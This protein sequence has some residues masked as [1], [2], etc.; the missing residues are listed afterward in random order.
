MWITEGKAWRK[1]ACLFAATALTLAG[2]AGNAQSPGPSLPR[3]GFE[4]TAQDPATYTPQ[5]AEAVALV[6]KWIATT[7]DHDTRKHMALVGDNVVFRADP[8][9]PLQHGARGYCAAFNFLTASWFGLNELYVVGTPSDTLV[10]MNRTDVNLPYNGSIY[11]GYPVPVAALL[12]VQNGRVV[13][14]FDMPT[15][16]VSIGALPSPPPGFGRGRSIP[17]RCGSVPGREVGATVAAASTGA[18][19]EPARTYGTSKPEYWFNPFEESA[20][21]TVRAW[22]AARQAGNPLLLGAFVDQN[23]NF[24]R[25]PADDLGK[26]RDNLLKTICGYIGGRLEL[27]DLFVVGGDYDTAV[28]TRWN[29]YGTN[30]NRTQMGSF[31]RVRNGLIVEWMDTA[32]DGAGTARG[33]GLN[34]TACQSVSVAFAARPA[35]AVPAGGPPPAGPPP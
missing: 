7:N 1:S 28:L 2:G 33:A 14:W 24:R 21:Q 5:E 3:Q 12:R 35:A 17:E 15:N 4:A 31:F 25:N 9:E 11:S 18:K 23:V 10:L 20:A 22:F 32:V 16:K 19:L 8:L 29:T 6:L 13:E 27:T 26:G 34:S 30:G